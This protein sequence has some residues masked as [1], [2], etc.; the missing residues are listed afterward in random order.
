MT[1]P[2][3]SSTSAAPVA[4]VT[5]G[6][7]SEEVWIQQIEDADFWTKVMAYIQRQ[8]SV[9]KS[10]VEIILKSMERQQVISRDAKQMQASVE[11]V[12]TAMK[13]PDDK[14]SVT[15]DSIDML[16]K[17]GQPV[18]DPDTNE[19]MDVDAFKAKVG[20]EQVKKVYSNPESL[21]YDE[22][23]TYTVEADRVKNDRVDYRVFNNLNAAREDKEFYAQCNSAEKEIMDKTPSDIMG[24]LSVDSKIANPLAVKYQ[25][26][27]YNRII[28]QYTKDHDLAQLTIGIKHFKDHD[29][30]YD[31]SM[32]I[33]KAEAFIKQE[34]DKKLNAAEDIKK[35]GPEFNRA[36]LQAIASALTS[37][38]DKMSTGA[39]QKNQNIQSD[40][41]EIQALITQL[42]NVINGKN[43]AAKGIAAKTAG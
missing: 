25:M 17:Y 5:K 14:K 26:V 41:G 40:L 42:T 34:T 23:T 10:G 22:K 1:T 38:S 29:Q 13:N 28:D 9:K 2:L 43:D 36:Q 19:T 4:P 37:L 35:S 21:R 6:P 12:T 32:P 33:D 16:R 30:A 24:F 20:G 8:L 7:D 15:E 11:S 31:T 18:V 27:K 3:P 39:Q